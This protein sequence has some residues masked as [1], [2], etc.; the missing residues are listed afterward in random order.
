MSRTRLPAALSAAATVAALAVPAATATAQA[1]SF[2][3]YGKAKRAQFVNHA[4]DR[5]RGSITNPFGPDILPTPPNAN[6]G[7]KGARAGDTVFIT[8]LLYA[9][10][11]LTRPAGTAI[12]S[13]RFNFGGEAFCDADFELR[14]GAIL[15]MGPAK[16]DGRQIALPVTGGTGRHFGAH[17]QVSSTTSLTSKYTQILRFTLL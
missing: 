2:V 16:L 4:D 11:K 6:S 7:K 8:I 9:D 14:R 12:I 13:C 17:G 1:H 10:H 15:A 5:E 3:L